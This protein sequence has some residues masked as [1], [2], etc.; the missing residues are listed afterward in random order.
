MIVRGSDQ[1]APALSVDT[2]SNSNPISGSP[3]ANSTQPWLASKKKIVD[4]I[5]S[6]GR[7]GVMSFQSVPPL[8]V[9]RSRRMLIAQ[10]TFGAS[11]FMDATDP[12]RRGLGASPPGL[13]A[14]A[15]PLP[16]GYCG[17]GS[18]CRGPTS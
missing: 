9:H 13:G 5:E 3:C 12:V 1:A 18:Q 16:T 4:T 10:P 14:G 8:E 7:S 11:S 17:G 2:R 6:F 15:T